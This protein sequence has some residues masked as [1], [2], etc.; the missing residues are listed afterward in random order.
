MNQDDRTALALFIVSDSVA[1][2]LDRLILIVSFVFFSVEAAF[3]D[4]TI[5]LG[6]KLSAAQLWPEERRAIQVSIPRKAQL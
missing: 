3:T 4:I 6:F 2:D 5:L 1:I